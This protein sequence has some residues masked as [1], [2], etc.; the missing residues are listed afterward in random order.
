MINTS[1]YN[2]V[3]ALLLEPFADSE[4]RSRKGAENKTFSYVAPELYRYRLLK[5]FTEGY[6]FGLTDIVEGQLGVRGVAHFKGHIDGIEYSVNGCPVFEPWTFSSSEP[7]KKVNPDQT[8][9]KLSS[10]GLKAVSREIGLGLHLYDKTPQ[11]GEAASSTPRSSAAA[12]VSTDGWDGE[13]LVGFGK[14]YPTTKWKDVPDDYL[15]FLTKDSD[16]D[17]RRPEAVAE[18]ARRADNN[19][20]IGQ[21][22]A[23]NAAAP[24][25]G[26]DE[27]PF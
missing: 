14:K 7:T 26:D 24:V 22:Q 3:A 9:M 5:V 17:K 21:E 19:V 1:E 23:S 13:K 11:E 8:Y 12:A 20:A 15:V 10:A 27:I 6:E 18:K 2:P 16:P 4:I 25:G